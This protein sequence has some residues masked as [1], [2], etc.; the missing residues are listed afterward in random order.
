MF[1][2]LNK[3]SYVGLYKQTRLHREPMPGSQPPSTQ[4]THIT[5]TVPANPSLHPQAVRTS[6]I[7]I[8]L[9]FHWNSSM[10]LKVVFTHL[11]FPPFHSYRLIRFFWF[12][13]CFNQATIV[14]SAFPARAPFEVRYILVIVL[15][16]VK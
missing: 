16:M 11:F 7:P 8:K 1:T 13:F 10:F 2:N 14:A 6:N 3:S 12:C 5:I 4:T 9:L 15:F